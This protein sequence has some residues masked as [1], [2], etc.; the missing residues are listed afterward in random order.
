[1]Q[2]PSYVYYA[3]NL[4]ASTEMATEMY[5]Y[6]A[7][8]GSRRRP[9]AEDDAT[10]GKR[11]YLPN[12]TAPQIVD[13]AQTMKNG[14]DSQLYERPGRPDPLGGDS[15]DEVIRKVGILVSRF[16]FPEQITRV[17]AHVEGGGTVQILIVHQYERHSEAI[18]VVRE[19]FGAFE[20]DVPGAY[21]EFTYARSEGFD[22]ADFRDFVDV[23][24]PT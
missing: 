9:A 10:V 16:G 2:E 23:P 13:Y 15:A 12:S 4:P 21:F 14:F 24:C 1:M 20:D 5:N 6:L 7:G 11:P 22:P 3:T 19:D 8:R 18:D 17:M